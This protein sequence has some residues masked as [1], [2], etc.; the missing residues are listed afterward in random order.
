M[1]GRRRIAIG[2]AG[3]LVLLVGLVL[4]GVVVLTQTD[5]GRER[6]RRLTLSQLA[7]SVNGVVEIGRISGNLLEGV[8]LTDLSIADT[9]G[10]PL[11]VADTVSVDYSL[12]SLVSKR[13][14]LARVRLVDPVIVLDRPPGG[15]WNFTRIF[16]SDTLPADTTARGFGS[17]LRIEG[18][19]VQGGRLVV[20]DA[21]SPPDSLRGAARER[22][23]AAALTEENRLHVVATA[24]G[25]QAI[26]EIRDLDAWL[27]L[28]RL[29]DPDSTGII[30]EVGSLQGVAYPFRPPAARIRDLSGRFVV[31]GD[32]IRLQDV[33]VELP[34]SR[35]SAEGALATRTGNLRARLHAQPIRAGDLRWIDP[36]LPDSGGGRVD[37]SI[38]VNGLRT[39][40]EARDLDLELDGV[41]LTGY[42][43]LTV[44]D[45][46]TLG[47]TELVFSGFDTRMTER[48]A[49]DVDLPVDGVF[50]GRLALSGSRG[51]MDVDAELVFVE[52]GGGR[53]R[54][55][56]DGEIEVGGRVGET[57]RARG[58]RV[59]L[60][61]L[62]VG[63]IRSFAPNLPV[64]GTITGTATVNGSPSSMIRIGAAHLVHRDAT[65]TSRL[66]G[67][68]DVGFEP[69]RF[70]AD[71]ALQ[72]VSLST[73]G[74][75]A[76]GA[77]L[78]GT[79]SGSLRARGTLDDL[80]VALDLVPND[81]G[82]LR[83]RGTLD[84]TGNLG[85]D[86]D[87][88]LSGLN[89]ARVSTRGPAT[90]LTGRVTAR[91]SGTAPA[92]LRAAVS[93]D[94]TNILPSGERAE[95]ARVRL[96]VGGGLAR[97]ERATLRLASATAEIEGRFGLEGGRQG[98]K[99]KKGQVEYPGKLD[100][101]P[102][103]KRES[104]EASDEQKKPDP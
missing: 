10:R 11:L 90:E 21:W 104:E 61:P 94:V 62:R 60:D 79:A 5:Y 15:E 74:R 64:G 29:A 47:P 101:P 91:G 26:R 54:V 70:D 12:R 20:R 92:T 37:V 86:L 63:L 87:L 75:F 41:R 78:Y 98:K 32:S 84:L 66:V 25:Y 96:Q 81:G 30:V 8:T 34:D 72:P 49:P 39:R 35:L 89:V 19:T 99:E 48:F 103:T 42:A 6:V 73:I 67:R 53:S 56:A 7:S 58:L 1:P 31:S 95:A 80:G 43:D 13:I 51:E 22:A 4:A 82:S 100:T 23:I 83:A 14:H 85:Y 17:W 71:F 88:D 59:R 27:P 97:V 44:G 38:A 68:V 3:V 45:S 76:P 55:T 40:V 77:G 52:R 2:A 16:A 36:T 24:N 46:L 9:E 18:L 50:D 28:L 93:A 65:G 33:R 102:E 57:I 69:Q